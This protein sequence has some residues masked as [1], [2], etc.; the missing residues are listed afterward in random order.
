MHIKVVAWRNS[1]YEQSIPG[2][3]GPM[4]K[5]RGLGAVPVQWGPMYWGSAVFAHD[6]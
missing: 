5:K 2:Q 6:G 3:W 1:K 4:Y